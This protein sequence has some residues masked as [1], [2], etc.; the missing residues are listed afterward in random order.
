[1]SAVDLA[2]VKVKY[3]ELH[4]ISLIQRVGAAGDCVIV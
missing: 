2:R 3:L 1:M 4:P